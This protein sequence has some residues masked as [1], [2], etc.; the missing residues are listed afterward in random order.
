MEEREREREGEG[1][2]RERE[3]KTERT[4]ECIYDIE[5]TNDGPK[6]EQKV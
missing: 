2:D 5:L 6:R 4:C 1:R 3:R